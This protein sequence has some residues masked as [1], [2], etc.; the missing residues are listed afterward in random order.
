MQSHKLHWHLDRVND[1]NQGKRI[2]PLHIDMGISRGCNIKCHYCFGIKQGNLY[3]KGSD[4]YMAKDTLV[5]FFKDAG[6]AGVRSIAIIGEAEPLMNP[7]VYEAIETSTVDLS[8][9]TNGILLNTSRDGEMALEKLKWIRFNISAA[10]H[11]SYLKIHASKDFQKVIDSIS[12]CVKRKR[13]QNLDVTIGLQMVL[14][15]KDIDEV[16]PLAKLGKELGVDYLVVKQC[17]DDMLNTLGV[18]KKLNK[19]SEQKYIDIFKEA[20]SLSSDSYSVI[21]KWKQLQNNGVRGYDNC[22]G[23]PFLLYGRGDGKLFSCGDFFHG[24]NEKY[25]LGD[26][27]KNSFAEILQSDQYWD[28]IAAVI[29]NI[30][31]HKD[32]YTNCRTNSINEYLWTLKHPPAHKNFI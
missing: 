30:D 2:P 4:Q 21:V 9:A 29:K 12:F 28:N 27:S 31:V 11:N 13:E 7:H 16:I 17:S 20:E 6:P 14:T 32:C 22:L 23:A 25:C 18:Y 26:L 3:G 1:W 8:L 10:S 15:P 19:N 5:N 24:E